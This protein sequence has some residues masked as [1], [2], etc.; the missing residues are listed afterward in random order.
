MA[1]AVRSGSLSSSHASFSSFPSPARLQGGRRFLAFRGGKRRIL[2]RASSWSSDENGHAVSRRDSDPVEVIGIGSR[3]DA[4]IDF[5]LSSHSV[6]ASRLRFW[7]I[8][9]VDSSK[10]QLLQRC[11]GTDVVLRDVEFPLTLH[12][13]PPAL[14]LV[15]SAGHG[16]DHITALELLRAVKSAGGLAVSIFLKPFSFEGQR[17]QQEADDLLNKL[18]QCSHLRIVVEADSLLETEV[19]TLAEALESSNNAV[20]LSIRT[21]SIMM[22]RS[23]LIFR[24][25]TD[26]EIEE[27]KPNVVIELL[28]RYGEAKVGF[29]AGYN[30]KSAIMQAVFHCP[31]LRG[32][33]KELNSVVILTLTSA[34]ILDESD[35]F[36]I[37]YTFRQITEFTKDI[38]FSQV[39]EPDLE[40]NLI[41]ITLLIVGCDRNVVPQKKG[42]F[43]S[44]ALRFPFLCSVLGRD[45]PVPNDSRPV[46]SPC[47][48]AEGVLSSIDKGSSTNSSSLE[49]INSYIDDLGAFPEENGP[50]RYNKESMSE[51]K[52]SG[53]ESEEANSESF[54]ETNK[55]TKGGFQWEPNLLNIGP[56]FHIAQLWAKERATLNGS[57]KIDELEIFT[58][59]V[60]VK[61]SVLRDDQ[62]PNSEP[63]QF[64]NHSGESFGTKNATYAESFTEAGLERVLGIY[65]FA[66]TLLKRKHVDESKKRGV[67]SSRA[68]SMLEAERELEKS[69]TPL[70]EIQYRGGT[71]RGR[72]QG[73]LPEGK[74]R[75]TFMD[76]SF[77]DGLWHCGKRSGLGML[78]YSNGDVFHG[79]WRD[80]LMHGKGWFYFRDGDR[81]FAN[82]W[83]GKANGEGR[84]YSN[85]GSIFFGHFKNGWRHGGSLL[86]DANGSRWTEIWDEGVL[87]NRTLLDKEVSG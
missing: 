58:L 13:C 85:N 27:V 57:N 28:E 61:S 82:F 64:E 75:L 72:C 68:A 31:F 37:I 24:N 41:A 47:E 48:S 53:I 12:P 26:G 32:G 52:T 11:N 51:K 74:G 36:S 29:G 35:L 66:L 4:V 55:P 81:W 71:Y 69:W 19:G 9:M 49:S 78:C 30:V 80:D 77:Y 6:S 33:I 84:F 23:H 8:H 16:L 59:P 3:K 22:S 86:I 2:V 20:L 18:H 38:I 45:F 44:L 70:M 46:H 17:R 83:K 62:Y 42:F 15:A 76:G 60:G 7:T 73:G 56:G 87:I 63:T 1:L 79:A 67:L 50:Q 65:N 43:S 40:P 21:I 39:C 34:C 5:C 54:S 14:I 25:S 10:V